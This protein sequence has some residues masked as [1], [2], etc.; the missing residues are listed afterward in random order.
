MKLNLNKKSIKRLSTD[1][2]LAMQATPQ[3]AGGR[4]KAISITV[5]LPKTAFA[6]KSLSTIA[7]CLRL[8][9]ASPL[10]QTKLLSQMKRDLPD[11]LVLI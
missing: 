5:H 9:G 2:A 4:P 7:R 8:S 11:N 6:G 1:K 3:V 10:A